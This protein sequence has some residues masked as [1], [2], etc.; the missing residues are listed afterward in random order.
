MLVAERLGRFDTIGIDCIAMNVN[1]L[2][3]VGAE[4]IAMLDFILC[5]EADPESA[6]RSATACARGAELAGIEIP[7][8]E[9]A[10]VGDIVS[11][12][13]LDRQRDRPR[14]SRRDRQRRADRARRRGHRPPLLRPA[15]ERLHARPRAL[16]R[17]AR[18]R[19]PRAAARR[20]PARADRDLRPRGARPARLRRR[21]PRPR[22]HHRRRAQQPAGSRAAVGYEID[23]PLPVPPVFGLI[24]ELGEV[25]DDEMH[26]VFNMGC[27][28]VC[29]VAAADERCALELLRAH[30]PAARRIGA[31]T[32]RAGDVERLARARTLSRALGA[33]VDRPMRIAILIFD[34]LTAL[35]AVG[36]YEVLSRLPGAELQLRR[37]ARPGRSA[38]TPA[39]SA[40]DR[41]PRARRARRPG[42]APRPR[43]RG[44]PAAARRRRGAR[45]AARRARDHDAGRP[46][47]APARWCSAPPGILDGQAR[48]QPLGL[49]RAARAT[50]APS[51]SPSGSSSTARS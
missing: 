15:L 9:I 19:A 4:P 50:S 51:R 23:D 17:P 31:V 48:D 39:P 36:P 7:G 32:D 43:R 49:P 34:R 33:T 27:G 12:W 5:R 13:E 18:R 41:R 46:R 26:E 21:R 30:H 40:L 24:A 1:D 29:V 38:P 8:G 3:C 22:P 42:L 47:S 35:D 28:F 20:G 14:R 44:Q 6:A 37:Q 45:L 10:Q 16:G 25:A 2:I 11:G